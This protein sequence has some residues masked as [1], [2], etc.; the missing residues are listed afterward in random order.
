MLFGKPLQDLS[1]YIVPYKVTS[2]SELKERKSGFLSPVSSLLQLAD[3][4]ARISYFWEVLK[5]AIGL[6]LDTSE[7]QLTG[8]PCFLQNLTLS[9]GSQD[10]EGAG[11][12]HGDRII[13]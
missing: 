13:P 5:H 3:F 12:I 2:G 8:A 6:E 4:S 7:E 11:L 9:A 1:D 10:H